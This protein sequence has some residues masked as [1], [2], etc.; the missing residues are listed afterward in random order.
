MQAYFKFILDQFE[1]EA[2]NLS[3]FKKSH[4]VTWNF[5][6]V[7]ILLLNYRNLALYD[8]LTFLNLLMYCIP[9]GV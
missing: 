3:N 2:S 1:G 9:S 7:S 8:K 6:Y 5:N 4:D